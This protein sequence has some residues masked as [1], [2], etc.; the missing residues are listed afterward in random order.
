[1]ILIGLKSTLLKNSLNLS[2]YKIPYEAVLKAYEDGLFP[3]AETADSKEIYWVDP[4]KRG[5]FFFDKI[6]IPR[7]LRKIAKMIL[8]LPMKPSISLLMMR[9]EFY[10]PRQPQS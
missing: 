6:K 8:L 10:V 3:M 4:N 7:K 9:I 1:M 2:N 5:I